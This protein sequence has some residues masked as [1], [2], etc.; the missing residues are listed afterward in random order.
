LV[1]VHEALLLELDMSM[2]MIDT[3]G[4]GFS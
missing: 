2:G 1:C 3:F 4:T